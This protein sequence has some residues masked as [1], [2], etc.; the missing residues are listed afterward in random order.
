MVVTVETNIGIT[1]IGEGGTKDTLEQCAGTLIGQ[2]PFRTEAL[3]QEA[4]I[5]WFYP[6]RREKAH[7]LGALD[8]APWD[9]KGKPLGLPIH[10]RLGGAA[11]EYCECYATGGATPPGTA[12]GTRL[13]LADRAR[14]TMEAGYRAFRMAPA[15]VPVGGVY[16]TRSVV[17]QVDQ[18]CKAVREAVGPNGNWRID[19][20]QRFDLKDAM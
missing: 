5:P 17:K 16:D 20:R 1:G 4:Y 15:A 18:D 11:G 13:S 19:L 8:P 9:I 12:P 2:S 10:Q 3:W 14:A 7:A 6:P